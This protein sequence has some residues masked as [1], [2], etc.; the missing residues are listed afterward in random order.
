MKKENKLKYIKFLKYFKKLGYKFIDYRKFKKKKNII[1]RHDVDFSLEYAFEIAKLNYK[2]KI[3]SHFFVLVNSPFYNILEDKNLHILENIISYNHNIGLHYDPGRLSFKSQMHL[4]KKVSPKIKNIF[5]THKFSSIKFKS[6]QY[7]TINFYNKK[8]SK[9]YYA[10]SGGSFRYGSPIND[11]D[12]IKNKESFQL[13]LHPIW[14]FYKTSDHKKIFKS[15][16]DDYNKS[17]IKSL[18]AYK[19]IKL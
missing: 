18:S 12:I 10:D 11:K 19:L 15:L 17:Q 6:N 5:S 9:K 8:L 2:E 1:L 16:I 13:N 14:W 3:K 7:K 4:L